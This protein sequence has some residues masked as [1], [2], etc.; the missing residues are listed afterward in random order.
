M[1]HFLLANG[2][3]G[4]S[5][6]WEYGTWWARIGRFVLFVRAPWSLNLFSERNGFYMLRIPLGSG[7]RVLLKDNGGRE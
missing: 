7:W 6:D 1:T 5:A 4:A 3:Y 2:K